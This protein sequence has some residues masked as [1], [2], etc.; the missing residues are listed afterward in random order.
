MAM[1]ALMLLWLQ[2][3]GASADVAR[4]DWLA[5]CW[6]LDSPRRVVEEQWMAPAGGVML[7]M[8]RTLVGDRTVEHEFVVIRQDEGRLTYTAHPSSQ[9]P[10]TFTARQVSGD[11][12]L[13]EN[14]QHDFPQR[15]RYR[16]QADQLVASI[17]GTRDG[18][19]RTVQ[20]A[21]ARVAC[22]GAR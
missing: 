1:L 22:A 9:S 8:S 3:P 15:I 11:E 6:R 4:L 14:P 18:R 2:A 17:E 16:R 12:V 7:G 13:F 19:A 5:G 21:Y 10:A 20:F